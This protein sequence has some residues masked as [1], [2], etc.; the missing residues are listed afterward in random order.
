[1]DAFQTFSAGTRLEANYNKFEIVIR[2]CH[3]KIEQDILNITRV[4]HGSLPFRYLG[5]PIT[6]SRLSKLEYR[7]LVDKTTARIKTWASR[8]L[9]YAGRAALIHSILLGIYTCWQK[10]FVLPQ[11]VINQVTKICRN[12]LWSADSLYKKPPL[13]CLG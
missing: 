13:C 9:S 10:I 4:K 7:S 2:G 8:H 1:M 5:V 11:E 12:H 6:A 3:P